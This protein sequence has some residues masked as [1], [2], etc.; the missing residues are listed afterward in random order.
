KSPTTTTKSPITTTKSPSSTIP[1]YTTKAP[2]SSCSTEANSDYF[3]FDL[4]TTAQASADACC[5]DCQATDGCKVWTWTNFN[6][7]TCW[8]KHS[9][10]RNS[11]YPGA[12]SGAVKDAPAS[13]G[14][15]Q[16]NADFVGNDLAQTAQA[17]PDL[18]CDDCKK[19]DGCHGFTWTDYNQG[20]CWL[21]S[22]TGYATAYNGAVSVTM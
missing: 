16:V 18:C 8:L 6:G 12:V 20:T 1:S 21:K 3:G 10:G 5:A 15:V 2:T 7:G 9:A 4:T 17:Y 22:D 14:T 11:H 13:C 19:T